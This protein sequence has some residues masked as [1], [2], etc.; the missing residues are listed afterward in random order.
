[1]ALS[2]LFLRDEF[3]VFLRACSE[4]VASA[5]LC[6]RLRFL[7]ISAISLPEMHMSCWVSVYS[8]MKLFSFSS[9]L[10]ERFSGLGEDFVLSFPNTRQTCFPRMFQ[11]L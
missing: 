4:W 6:K 11:K 8:V 1:M 3:R 9:S 7:S 2:S 5:Q 10:M